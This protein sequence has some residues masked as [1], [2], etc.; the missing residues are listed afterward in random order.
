MTKP[1]NEHESTQAP[2][3]V[4]GELRS[5]LENWDADAVDEILDDWVWGD[6][7]AAFE[8]AKKANWKPKAVRTGKPR[9]R[10]SKDFGPIEY[11]PLKYND[12]EVYHKQ[13]AT[14]LI[15][16]NESK[17]YRVIHWAGDIRIYTDRHPKPDPNDFEA[18]VHWNGRQC[19]RGFWGYEVPHSIVGTSTETHPLNNPD[20]PIKVA[21]TGY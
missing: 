21:K 8:Y 13:I 5:A 20:H 9:L 7:E 15:E 2:P 14:N 18:F 12:S 4:W 3:E 10:H 19:V 17:L 11:V 6:W 16:V 1:K